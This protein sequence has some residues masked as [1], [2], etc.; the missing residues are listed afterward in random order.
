MKYIILN[1]EFIKELPANCNECPFHLCSLPL[2]SNGYEIL[3]NCLKKRHPKCPF[4]E[5]EVKDD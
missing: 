5:L 1:P 2:K 4:S 3:K